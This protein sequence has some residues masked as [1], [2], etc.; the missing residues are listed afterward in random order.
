MPVTVIATMQTRDGLQDD[1]VRALAEAT[2][3]F[4]AEEGCLKYTLH[5]SGSSRVIVIESWSDKES[6]TAHASSPR[7]TEV[8]ARLKEMLVGDPQ[9]TFAKPVSAGE[10]IQGTI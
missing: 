4:H 6:L 7:F 5:T 8:N 2:E 10:L 1:V 9:I 3:H